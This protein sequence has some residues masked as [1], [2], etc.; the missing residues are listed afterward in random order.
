MITMFLA[1][2]AVSYSISETRRIT[3]GNCNDIVSSIRNTM[4]RPNSFPA[5]SRGSR[6]R[7]TANSAFGE[8]KGLPVAFTFEGAPL[9]STVKL[10]VTKPE[11]RYSSAFAG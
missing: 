4:R 8:S 5:H 2:D 6:M 7:I 10:T 3:S 1:G 9:L 11:T